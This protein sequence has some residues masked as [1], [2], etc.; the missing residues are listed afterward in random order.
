MLDFVD[1]NGAQSPL[2]KKDGIL[3]PLHTVN[4]LPIFFSLSILIG[5]T[6]RKVPATVQKI[7]TFHHPVK[8]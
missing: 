7:A 3:T 8:I 2:V 5:N 1:K 6:F 4:F